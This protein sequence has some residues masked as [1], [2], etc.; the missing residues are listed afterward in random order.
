MRDWMF[1]S[2]MSG[3]KAG[4]E[5][6]ESLVVLLEQAV[7]GDEFEADAEIFG[8]MPAVVDGA[9]RGIGAGHADA[10]NVFRAEGFDGDGG[11]EGGVDAAAEGDEGLGEAA[12]ADV[13][14]R[15]EDEGAKDRLVLVIDLR[16][17]GAGERFGVDED[18]VFF[19][20][21]GLGDDLAVA[22]KG[23]AEPSKMRLSL[24]PTWLTMSTG[25]RVATRDGGEHLAARLALVAPVGRGGDVE[26]DANRRR[27]SALRRDRWCRGGSPRSSC[28]SRRLR[29]W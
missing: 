14:A 10:E 20:R 18:Q 28:R 27:A 16:M 3:L 22:A 5:G 29:R 17:H 6:R 15:A 26:N 24:P 7:D 4:E 13:V 2:V 19:E 23:E 8:E 25:M 9:L 12:L 21:R 11:D 1:S